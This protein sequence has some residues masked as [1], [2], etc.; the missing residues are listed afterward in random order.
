MPLA[1][2]FSFFGCDGIIVGVSMSNKLANMML[3]VAFINVWATA[4][5]G[6]SKTIVVTKPS[7]EVTSRFGHL[8]FR[9][10]KLRFATTVAAT[11]SEDRDKEMIK[12]ADYYV[13]RL[14]E[15][16]KFLKSLEVCRFQVR[17]AGL[18]FDHQRSGE[19]FNIFSVHKN[20]VMVLKLELVKEMKIK[21][22][23][24]ILM[25]LDGE[26]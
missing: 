23:K 12:R 1:V 11:A 5:C 14:E 10:L 18:G 3:M 8:F 7:F 4:C 16:L 17:E 19:E 24:K 21:K 6:D 15:C 26:V 25:V 20:L 2:Q 22:N 9:I 13:P